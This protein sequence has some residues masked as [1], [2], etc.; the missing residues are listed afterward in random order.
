MK[1]VISYET[2]FKYEPISVKVDTLESEPVVLIESESTGL[3]VEIP[4]DVALRINPDSFRQVNERLRKEISNK[5]KEKY[6]PT[7]ISKRVVQ[8]PVSDDY[9]E[10]ECFVLKRDND[11]TGYLI[12]YIVWRT[13]GHDFKNDGWSLHLSGLSEVTLGFAE[14]NDLAGIK[15]LILSLADVESLK[16]EAQKQAKPRYKDLI[17]VMKSETIIKENDWKKDKEIL[18]T[19]A[20]ENSNLY[21]SL[22]RLTIQRNPHFNDSHSVY[23]L[24]F[25]APQI[26]K[27]PVRKGFLDRIGLAENAVEAEATHIVSTPEELKKYTKALTVSL[28]TKGW[29]LLAYHEDYPVFQV[30]VSKFT[31]NEVDAMLKAQKI[32]YYPSRPKV[33]GVEFRKIAQAILKDLDSL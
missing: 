5:R 27:A 17:A 14:W 11:H 32:K 25:H 26:I 33:S 21:P 22:D 3:L 13:A 30:L 10:Q 18:S 24:L 7:R 28:K 4:I 15:D 19:I 2:S 9:R 16:L 23:N 20:A 8:D 29:N 1:P 6:Y 12:P 31:N